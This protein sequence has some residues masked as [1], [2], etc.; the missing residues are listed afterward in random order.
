MAFYATLY[1]IVCT[2]S[3][4]AIVTGVNKNGIGFAVTN[5]LLKRGIRCLISDVIES[6]AQESAKH[7]QQSYGEDKVVA[8]KVDVTK[9]E[10]LKSMIQTCMERFGQIDV[11]RLCGPFF[12]FVV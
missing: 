9:T 1:Q 8:M 10:D 6:A 4:V 12:Q 7:L 2:H 3:Q 11:R 5:Y